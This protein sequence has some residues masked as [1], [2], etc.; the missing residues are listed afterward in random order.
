MHHTVKMYGG[1]AVA[2]RIPNRDYRCRRVVS[3]KPQLLYPPGRSSFYA[4]G[5]VDSSASLD[6]EE[7]RKI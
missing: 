3:L 4:A 1:V 5:W 7:K 6:S 2:S